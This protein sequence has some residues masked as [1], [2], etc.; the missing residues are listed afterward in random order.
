MKR[1]PMP[2]AMLF[3]AA[4]FL[5]PG[6]AVCGN[7]LTNGSFQSGT[8][9]GWTVFTTPDGSLGRGLPVVTLFNVTGRGPADAAEFNVGELNGI[10]KYFAGGGL[11]QD[12]TTTGGTFDLSYDFAAE[13]GSVGNAVG[14]FFS[15]LLNGNPLTADGV[16]VIHPGQIVRGS[17]NTDLTLA[18]GTYQFEILITRPYGND[19]ITPFQYVTGASVSSGTEAEALSGQLGTRA[20]EP[21]TLF[22]F[23]SGL[24]AVGFLK[25]KL[26]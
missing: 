3:A 16:G 14:G 6:P 21:A 19:S 23:A 22:L 7:L 4:L 17:L 20:P 10:T 25:G 18:A 5:A 11:Y 2:V 13:G 15:L 24:L 9:A 8:L 1:T 12:F 26:M